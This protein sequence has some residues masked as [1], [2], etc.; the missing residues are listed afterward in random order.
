MNRITDIMFNIKMWW[1]RKT[2]GWADT[3][4]WNLETTAAEWI[5]PRL[6]ALRENTIGYPTELES[7][8]SWEAILDEMIFGFEFYL[9][10][11]EEYDRRCFSVKKKVSEE[12]FKIRLA[13][14]E[15]DRDRAQRGREL[16]GKWFG[17]LWW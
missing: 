14:Y 12:E 13:E 10:E 2:R 1:Q 4:I 6:K 11:G 16:F 15:T 17:S 9:K 8:E 3:D 7:F 5:L